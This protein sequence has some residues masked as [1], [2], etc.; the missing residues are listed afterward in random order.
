MRI[1]YLVHNLAD[2]AVAKRVG[3]LQAAGAEVRLIGFHREGI[4]MASFAD[5][6]VL[7]LGRTY[8]ASFGQRVAM[9]LKRRIRSGAWAKRLRGCDLVIARNLEMLALAAASRRY[10]R[11]AVL[12]YE[13]LDIHRLLLNDA[14]IGTA[15]RAMERW[16]LR[17]VDLI[18]VSSP[19]FLREYF[20]A[21]LQLTRAVPALVIENKMAPRPDSELE[22]AHAAPVAAGPPWHIGWFGMIRCRKSLDLLCDLAARRPDLLRVTIRGRPSRTEFDDFDAQISQTPGVEY[23]GTYGPEELPALY[24]SVHFN[25]AIDYFEEGANS[26]WLLPNRI[27]EGGAYRAVPLA[28]PETETARWLEAR[29]LGAILDPTK[30]LETFLARLTAETYAGLKAACHGAPISTFVADSSDCRLLLDKVREL[31]LRR[32]SG[33]RPASIEL[34]FRQAGEARDD[35]A[36]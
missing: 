7:D 2:P 23:G 30:A 14:W 11:N 1:A 36:M 18:V 24:R 33:V 12:V 25:W 13:C 8:D 34:D 16:F 6:E 3:M 35:A 17:R 29:G 20:A 15:M 9:V 21:R 26:R 28:R 19:A 4:P 31:A 22:Q 10:A 32:A 5:V 27:Y